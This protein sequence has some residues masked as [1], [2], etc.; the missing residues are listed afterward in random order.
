MG[1][2]L[3]GVATALLV[4]L[5]APRMPQ[6]AGAD[7]LAGAPAGLNFHWSALCD[8]PEN[9]RV[10]HRMR[11]GQAAFVAG[12][13]HHAEE[14]LDATLDAIEAIYADN[15]A[16]NKARSVYHSE[17]SKDFKGEP[18]ERVMA[19]YYR[20][21]LYTFAGDWGN[22]RAAFKG[23]V[24]QDTFAAQERH[25]A[26]VASLVWLEGWAN[27]C[28]GNNVAAETLFAEA[29]ALRP[30]LK[31]P[32]DNAN[33]LIVAEPGTGPRK[34][35][36]GSYNEILGFREGGRGN[37]R[38][39][40]AIGGTRVE[41]T[42]AEDV[43]FQ[44]ITRGGREMDKILVEK[45]K[46]K[47]G[48]AQFGNAAMAAG[49]ATMAVSSSQR[50]DS[51]SGSRAAAAAGGVGLLIGLL[52]HAN[53][54]AMNPEADTRTWDTLPHSIYLA[55]LPTPDGGWADQIDILDGNGISVL[56][57]RAGLKTV[58]HPTCSLAW[59]GSGGLLPS[60][61][62]PAGTDVTPLQ[63]SPDAPICRTAS[64]ADKPLPRDICRRIGGTPRE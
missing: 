6:A 3:N 11:A 58:T 18:F 46:A 47:E 63:A 25:R 14:Q 48:S 53:A 33:L 37:D 59:V 40:V 44:A 19:Y 2:V 26:D 39:V 12:H 7:C 64:G 16:A 1:H 38:L 22:A 55:A 9:D 32:A 52:A 23:G 50:N 61:V 17:K 56:P 27:R 5:L 24:L 35:S 21:L 57:G 30:G 4:V 54:A 8:S 51:N 20:G 49:M 45:A 31:P 41:M 42:E 43:F 36:S 34:F 62:I 15:E 60:R 13:F 28:Q 10:L 29:R